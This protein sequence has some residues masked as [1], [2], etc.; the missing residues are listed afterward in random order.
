MDR[1]GG[2]P[3]TPPPRSEFFIRRREARGRTGRVES[4]LAFRG[5]FDYSLDAKNRLNIPPKFR[6]AFADGV[7]L[8]QWIDPCV[9]IWTP[10]GFETFTAQ[11]LPDANPLSPERRR[12]EGYFAHNSFDVTLDAAGRVT[13]NQDLIDYAGLGKDVIVAG[14]LNH[15]QVWDAK[16]WRDQ[17]SELAGEV[18]DIAESLGNA[19]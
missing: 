15:L 13:L 16:R 18:V 17:Q 4:R 6:P 10:E 12:V 8:A 19:S 2:A 1:G 11:L 5:H 9:T 7:V 3:P 14:T